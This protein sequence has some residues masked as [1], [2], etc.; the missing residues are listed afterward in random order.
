MS[1][2]SGALGSFPAFPA[3]GDFTFEPAAKFVK[4]VKFV[5]KN[6]YH[7]A[8]VHGSGGLYFKCFCKK[9]K[10]PLLWIS[11]PPAKN[12]IS[13]RSGNFSRE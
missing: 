12:S 8:R 6:S 7:I 1:T 13:V 3:K 4:F 9:A 5:A 10:V 2:N 11:W